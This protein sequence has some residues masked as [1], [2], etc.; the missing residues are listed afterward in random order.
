MENA[1][2]ILLSIEGGRVFGEQTDNQYCLKKNSA[3]C[4]QLN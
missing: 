2:G 4:E 3:S 1:Y